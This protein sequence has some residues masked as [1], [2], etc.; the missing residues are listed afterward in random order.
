MADLTVAN[1]LD[2]AVA[3]LKKDP[4]QPVR[5]RVGDITVEV[6]AVV[7]AGG[8]QSAGDIFATIGPWAG[9]TTDELLRL[10]S[11]ARRRSGR[12]SVPVDLV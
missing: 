5:A 7:E 3:R 10:L 2:Q 11:E 8:D 6:R 9:E 4:S 12:D 1:T